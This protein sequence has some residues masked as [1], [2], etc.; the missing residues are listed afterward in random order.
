MIGVNRIV[1]SD[2]V[3]DVETAPLRSADR[4]APDRAHASAFAPSATHAQVTALLDKLV[5]VAKD[6]TQNIM[7]V[8]IELG[9]ERRDHGRHRRDA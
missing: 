5:A 4:R 7:P 2:E 1:E 3:L 8:T 6:D 9:R